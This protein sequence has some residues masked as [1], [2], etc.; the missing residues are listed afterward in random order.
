MKIPGI[1][2]KTMANPIDFVHRRFRGCQSSTRNCVT[3]ICPRLAASLSWHRPCI[4]LF[5]RIIIA[6]IRT[7]VPVNPFT[8]TAVD[9]STRWI[10][11]DD[12]CRAVPDRRFK[13]ETGRQKCQ[14]I[15]KTLD[16]YVIFRPSCD[17][18]ETLL[19]SFTHDTCIII[20]FHVQN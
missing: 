2:R 13:V 20:F 16:L 8:V 18:N 19:P 10:T 6:V 14:I 9:C 7:Y 5:E 15:V 11:K 4:I 1:L 12:W 17:Y 3:T